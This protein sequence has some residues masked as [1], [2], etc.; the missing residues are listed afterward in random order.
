MVGPL[1]ILIIVTKLVADLTASRDTTFGENQMLTIRYSCLLCLVALAVGFSFS[2][3]CEDEH[4]DV[5]KT[6][7]QSFALRDEAA[8]EVLQLT[9]DPRGLSGLVFADGAERESDADE[10]PWMRADNGDIWHYR[11]WQWWQG[12]PWGDSCRPRYWTKAPFQFDQDNAWATIEWRMDGFDTFQQFL[13]PTVVDAEAPYWDLVIT[14]RNVSGKAVDEYGQFF[15]CYTRLNRD[16]S[17]WFWNAAGKLELFSD[18]GVTHLDGYVVHP[19]AYF[20]AQGAIS[21]CPRGDGKIVGQW[22]HPVIISHASAAGRRSVI[23][24][25]EEYT[26]S[27]AHGIR[28]GA[29]DYIV[30]PG[31]SAVK[32]A[33]G[34]E[35]KVHVRHVMLK[36]PQLPSMER[37]ES[38]WQDFADAHET[39]HRRA[40]SLMNRAD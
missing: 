2:W 17:F 31:P 28:G 9:F 5:V 40:A 33:S 20:V 11:E 35:F 19:D 6:P 3:A 30:F 27:L 16:R 22:G 10:Q 13:L 38:L 14:V 1:P 34:A 39:V 12:H 23:L 21:H 32:F 8:G 26:A 4:P 24:L 7:R 36:S 18:R 29:M 25:E 15:A 37:V